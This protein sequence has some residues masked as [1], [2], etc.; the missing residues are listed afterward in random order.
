MRSIPRRWCAAPPISVSGVRQTS[1]RA[2]STPAIAP[3]ANHV[4]LLCTIQRNERRGRI[5]L[6]RGRICRFRVDPIVR[7]ARRSGGC[8]V[9]RAP[10]HCAREVR[11]FGVDDRDV[12]APASIVGGGN[13]RLHDGFR[14]SGVPAHQAL[15]GR[16]R[17][18][19]GQ[20][21]RAEQDCGVP[22]EYVL[23]DL[24]VVVFVFVAQRAADVAEDLMAT[25]MSHR[26]DFG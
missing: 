16:G 24:D 25:R 11:S 2:P 20:A 26:V 17:D 8:S 5:R 9:R 18:H 4:V 10:T 14:S 1:R 3:S 12:V 13:Q 23:H 7:E 15:D 22:L 6:R 19:V 21:I